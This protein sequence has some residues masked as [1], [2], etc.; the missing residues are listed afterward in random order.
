METI[1]INYFY[2]FKN[3]IPW[4]SHILIVWLYQIYI[5]YLY[6]FGKNFKKVTIISFPN[7]WFISQKFLINL[8]F[9]YLI[10]FTIC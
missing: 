3:L 9:D 4:I 8:Q 1:D 7:Y 10:I 5:N 2:N 6:N